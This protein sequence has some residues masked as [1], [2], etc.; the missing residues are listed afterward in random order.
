MLNISIKSLLINTSP[1]QKVCAFIRFF[2]P[3]LLFTPHFHPIISEV[4]KHLGIP[5]V[6]IYDHRSNK[7]YQTQKISDKKKTDSRAYGYADG[8]YVGKEGAKLEERDLL[9]MWPVVEEAAFEVI[10]KH[11]K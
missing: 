1:L 4:T 9:L 5:V 8:G 2:E 11:Y 7:S 3:S 10:A 6:S